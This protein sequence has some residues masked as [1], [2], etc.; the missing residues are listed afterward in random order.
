VKKLWIIFALFIA[1]EA[2]RIFE[3][4][5]TMA[6]AAEGNERVMVEVDQ[7]HWDLTDIARAI[8]ESKP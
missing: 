4:V 1:F 5:H 6:S 7:L 3:A 2:G 8:R